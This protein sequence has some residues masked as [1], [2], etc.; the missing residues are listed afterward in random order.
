MLISLAHSTESYIIFYSMSFLAYPTYP[1]LSS[2]CRVQCTM[3]YGK[4]KIYNAER[5]GSII[6]QCLRG[7]FNIQR[8][9]AISNTYTY[10][11]TNSRTNVFFFSSI[12]K[13][14]FTRAQLDVDE[15]KIIIF[16][17]KRFLWDI[18]FFD[19]LS[20]YVCNTMNKTKKKYIYFSSAILL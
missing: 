6:G 9:L 7:T 16:L 1:V 20:I 15:L 5:R 18:F 4:N 14:D 8:V 3:Q 10:A 2:R 19:V 12:R 13:Y 17:F 11:W